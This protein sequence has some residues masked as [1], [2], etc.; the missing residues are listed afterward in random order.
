MWSK[1]DA[2][3]RLIEMSKAPRM[4]ATTSESF[5]LQVLVILESMQLSKDK[6]NMLLV[7]NDLNSIS[8][9]LNDNWARNLIQNILFE[10]K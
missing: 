9:E 7:I 5:A 2:I 1:Q 4:W 6:I 8:I 3:N 10:I